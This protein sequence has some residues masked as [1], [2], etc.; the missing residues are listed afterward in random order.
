MPFI[1]ALRV[2]PWSSFATGFIGGT[3]VHVVSILV[4]RLGVDDAVDAAAVHA[5]KYWL[6][7]LSALQT[8][9]CTL[10]PV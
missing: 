3:V 1:Q 6:D 9:G 8:H 10:T 5:G 4:E 2:E 7:Q